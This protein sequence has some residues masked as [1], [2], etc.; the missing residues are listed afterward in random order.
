MSDAPADRPD[1]LRAWLEAT[2]GDQ[3]QRPPESGDGGG[4]VGPSRR[5]MAA[6]AVV[7]A[8]AVVL[9]VAVRAKDAGGQTPDVAPPAPTVS[10]TPAP[11]TPAT[12]TAQLEGQGLAPAG[13]P[14]VAAAALL[15][16]RTGAGEDV[17]VDTAAVEATADRGGVTV[18]TVRALILRRLGGGWSRPQT[19]R[20]AVPVSTA[21][22]ETNAL[23]APWRLPSPDAAPQGPA[24]AAVEDAGL[25]RKAAAAIAAAGY[26]SPAGASVRRAADLTGV[27]AVSVRAVAPGDTDV[28]SH[29][30]WLTEDAGAVLGMPAVTDIPVPGGQ[31]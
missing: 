17:Y 4:E 25:A 18:V 1:P 14:A 6:T 27:L 5:L 7:C 19:V 3:S 31:P 10:A 15:A 11:A 23:A 8:T 26:S 29:E 13:D 28:R 30:L 12:A 24:W 20:F 16:V 9:A 2:G 21:G 22:G